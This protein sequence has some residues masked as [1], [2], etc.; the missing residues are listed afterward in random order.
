MRKGLSREFIVMAV[1][2]VYEKAYV[3]GRIPT[4]LAP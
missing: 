3:I 1:D 2:G 4:R